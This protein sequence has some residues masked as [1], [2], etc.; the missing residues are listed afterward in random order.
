MNSDVADDIEAQT[1]KML[2]ETL[3]QL[4]EQQ[5]ETFLRV[6]PRGVRAKDLESAIGLCRRTVRQN[7]GAAFPYLTGRLAQGWTEKGNQIQPSEHSDQKNLAPDPRCPTPGCQNFV[8]SSED[9]CTNCLES[10]SSGEG[11]P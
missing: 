5:R 6:Y 9:Y 10:H 4:T 3:E 2:A 11:K 7:A 1:R 8:E